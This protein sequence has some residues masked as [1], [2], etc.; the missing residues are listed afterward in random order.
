MT[1]IRITSLNKFFI[2]IFIILDKKFSRQ[3]FEIVPLFFQ[4][5]RF[6]HFMQISPG[7]TICMNC[8]IL[9][10][11]KNK[12]QETICM[13]CQIFFSVKNRKNIISVLSAEFVHSMPC[14]KLNFF[15]M[16]EYNY[17]LNNPLFRALQKWH[18]VYM[19]LEEYEWCIINI[20]HC[21]LHTENS[22]DPNHD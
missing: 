14:V 21:V 12:T 3:H 15:S 9:F 16:A 10:S 8:Q 20:H 5:I 18:V 2:L 1:P 19:Y 4:K 11:A 7:M 17:F 22:E 6:G 13:K